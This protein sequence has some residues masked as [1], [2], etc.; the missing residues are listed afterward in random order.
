MASPPACSRASCPCCRARSRLRLPQVGHQR[1]VQERPPQ[2]QA[3]APKAIAA[4]AAALLI[5]RCSAATS[6]S[7]VCATPPCRV[8][9]LG[10]ATCYQLSSQPRSC[11]MRPR[12]VTQRAPLLLLTRAH[13]GSRLRPPRRR[14]G[15]GARGADAPAAAA[16]AAW[17]ACG[18][19]QECNRLHGACVLGRGG[20]LGGLAASGLQ[21]NRSCPAALPPS[22]LAVL[23]LCGERGGLWGG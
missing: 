7:R 22:L 12:H 16:S 9:V 21:C 13:P 15:H 11:L 23:Q 8:T 10:C 18:G 2:A 3:A 14:R 1:H 17:L 19:C 4:A 5:Q 6:S 20:A